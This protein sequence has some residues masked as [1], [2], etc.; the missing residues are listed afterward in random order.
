[1]A[2]RMLNKEPP[3]TI[4]P[5]NSFGQGA[6]L[7]EVKNLACS[8]AEKSLLKCPRDSI[9]TTSVS[10]DCFFDPKHVGIVCGKQPSKCVRR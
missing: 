8:G 10:P 7:L 5:P 2:C 4:P 9:S 6:H 3:V 1:M